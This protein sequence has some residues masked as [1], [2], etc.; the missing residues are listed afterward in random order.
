M[1]S[2]RLRLPRSSQGGTTTSSAAGAGSR[3][4]GQASG[5]SRSLGPTI[6]KCFASLQKGLLHKTSLYSKGSVSL[7]GR[8]LTKAR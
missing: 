3:T 8:S 6:S 2:L 5:R 7:C 4:L 1:R